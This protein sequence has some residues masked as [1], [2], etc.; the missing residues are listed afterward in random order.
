MTLRPNC[1]T[2]YDTGFWHDD[3]IPAD[4]K[5][6]EGS[7]QIY[8]SMLCT[9]PVAV[10]W[11]EEGPR[12]GDFQLGKWD[13]WCHSIHP[14]HFTWN[15]K[16]GTWVPLDFGIIDDVTYMWKLGLRTL[17]SCEGEPGVSTRYIKFAER[18]H[19]VIAATRLGW[20]DHFDEKHN[21]VYGHRYIPGD[22]G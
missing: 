16:E 14:T 13:G 21:A 10:K 15:A 17:F 19:A 18:E 22:E 12:N 7:R 2:C 20:V 4:P 1:L 9:C 8:P 3:A 11:L 6:F 5:T